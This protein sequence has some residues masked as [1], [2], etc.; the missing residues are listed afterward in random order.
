MLLFDIKH[1]KPLFIKLPFGWTLTPKLNILMPKSLYSAFEGTRYKQCDNQPLWQPSPV[2]PTR[3]RH[4]VDMILLWQRM[5]AST[6]QGHGHT[7]ITFSSDHWR[8]R[9]SWNC[10]VYVAFSGTLSIKCIPCSTVRVRE[11]AS[12]LLG[13]QRRPVACC[14]AA[15]VSRAPGTM[16]FHQGEDVTWWYNHTNELLSYS[17]LLCPWFRVTVYNDHRSHCC[18]N[19]W[20]FL[21][22]SG[23]LSRERKSAI[24]Y[25]WQECFFLLLW[26]LQ[27]H[28]ATS[29]SSL[30]MWCSTS[31]Q[32]IPIDPFIHRL[33]FIYLFHFYPYLTRKSHWD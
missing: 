21:L 8:G 23:V 20:S 28:P 1:I 18:H 3:L 13:A 11:Q 16:D 5:A 14:S 9:E 12:K 17:S 30:Y 29:S 25:V 4:Q 10:A 2:S 26:G 15:R 6:H 33:S 7:L 27:K 32:M 19:R 24:W 22:D 31:N